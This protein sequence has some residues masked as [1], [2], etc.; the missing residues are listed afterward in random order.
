MP[1]GDPFDL[2]RFVT[3]QDPVFATVID[4]LRNGRKRSHWMWFIF[5]QLR[6]LGRSPT[7]QFYGIASMDEA[8][9][10]LAHPA[11]GPRLVQ[12][13]ETVLSVRERTLHEIFGSPDDLKFRSCMTLFAETEPAGS[14][15]RKALDRYCDGRPDDATL[16]LLG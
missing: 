2:Q 16:A 11:L 1:D 3:A 8:R 6:A 5:P 14:L 9:A 10:Y 15:Y 12:A 13:T 4:E 7:A